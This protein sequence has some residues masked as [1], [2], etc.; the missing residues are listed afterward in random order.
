M[1]PCK[2]A[3]LWVRTSLEARGSDT[4]SGTGWGLSCRARGVGLWVS[5]S[6]AKGLSSLDLRLQLCSEW[7]AGLSCSS[8]GLRGSR[9]LAAWSEASCFLP[10]RVDLWNASNLKF[11]DEFLG[12]LR[13][14]LKVLRQSSPHEAW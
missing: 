10:S 8:S 9:C 4:Q 12:E 5:S 14:P 13:V 2:L 11:G 3:L 7:P 6:P 1:T